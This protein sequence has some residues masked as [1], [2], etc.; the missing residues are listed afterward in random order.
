MASDDLD[1]SI[2]NGLQ[3]DD[4]LKQALLARAQRRQLGASVDEQAQNRNLLAQALVGLG[5]VF[6]SAARG[7]PSSDLAMKQIDAVQNQEANRRKL[8]ALDDMNQIKALQP[9]LDERKLRLQ[10][11]LAIDK[12]STLAPIK[13][14]AQLKNQLELRKA[15]G[16]QDADKQLRQLNFLE[17]QQGRTFGHQDD[18]QQRLFDQNR[19][20]KELGQ[21]HAKEL[22]DL[23]AQHAKELQS[24][25]D[26]GKD[27]QGKGTSGPGQARADRIQL[28][29]NKQYSSE[30]GNTE[31][32]LLSAN[33]VLKLTAGI[34]AEELKSTPQLKSDLSGALATMINQGRPATVYGMQHQ[35]FDSAWGSAQKALGYLSGTT[36][37]TMT[38]AQL[39][40]LVK[41]INVLKKEYSIQ[42][43]Q[44]FNAFVEGLPESTRPMLKNR[45][46]TFRGTVLKNDEQEN[47]PRGTNKSTI[48]NSGGI[49]ID[50]SKLGRE[51][52]I[53]FLRGQ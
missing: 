28:Q 38:N 40:Q 45:F 32:Q 6:E 49:N 8:Q 26:T 29:A 21:S 30:L 19:E 41:D 17:A 9:L 15:M 27:A 36:P 13:A 51:Q 31:T 24:L 34:T 23:R 37:D 25:K 39:G 35:E 7:H 44:K 4:L 20:M 5:G 3:D 22:E 14:A 11:Q 50:V 42:H 2:D 16:D 12:E 18:T 48:V 46:N 43:Q 47:V 33:K 52:K 1:E 10:N 53:K